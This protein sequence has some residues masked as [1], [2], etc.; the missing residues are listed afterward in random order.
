MAITL[1]SLAEQLRVVLEKTEKLE[2][3]NE[4]LRN[5]QVLRP[6]VDNMKI[7]T[8]NIAPEH[9]IVLSTANGPDHLTLKVF[10]VMPVYLRKCKLAVGACFTL[11]RFVDVSLVLLDAD[12]SKILEEKIA[13]YNPADERNDVEVLNT[14]FKRDGDWQVS[15]HLQVLF[16]RFIR[17]I[18]KYLFTAEIQEIVRRNYQ[19][20]VNTADL[21]AVSPSIILKELE[22]FRKCSNGQRA[23]LVLSRATIYVDFKNVLQ[24]VSPSHKQTLA[25]TYAVMQAHYTDVEMLANGTANVNA[26]ADHIA[27]L[28]S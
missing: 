9:S 28:S 2:E 11:E 14:D 27:K 10:E 22:S 3:E 17:Y 18:I 15:I 13:N 8:T 12:S 4:R 1:E 21:S 23:E 20:Y 5:N 24:R 6:Q 16:D 19:T 26:E 7:N 25:L